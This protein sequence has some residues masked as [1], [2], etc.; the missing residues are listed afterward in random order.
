M[1]MSLNL[2]PAGEWVAA[3]IY[4]TLVVLAVTLA[5]VAFLKGNMQPWNYATLGGLAAV[6]WAVTFSAISTAG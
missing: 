3:G 1:R 6:G 5:S 4:L 2:S